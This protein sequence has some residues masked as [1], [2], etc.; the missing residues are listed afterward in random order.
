MSLTKPTLP[1]RALLLIG[2]GVALAHLLLLRELPAALQVQ[3][4][5]P[6]ARALQTRSIAAPPPPV[7]VAPA[8]APP[9]ARPKPPPAPP[10]VQA[11]PTSTTVASV[12][13]P[14][15][16][17]PE[18]AP[19]PEPPASAPEVPVVTPPAPPEPA[20]S[21]PAPPAPPAP[22]AVTQATA[23]AFPA[24]VHLLYELSGESKK[25]RYQARGELQWRQDGQ[26]YDA[27][28]QASMLFFG[29]RTRTSSGQIT[30]SGLAP[31]RF[32]DKWRSEQAAHF[33]QEKHKVTFSANTP[34]VTLQAAAQD[35]LSVILQI[36]GMLAAE[37]ASY[38]A[39]S[40]ITLQTVG[41][42]DADIWAF[43]VETP[44]KIRVPSG[45]LETIKLIRKPRK[46]FDQ[47]VEIWLAP[48]L[49]YLP[50]RLKITNANGDFIDQQ[51]RG[52][53]KP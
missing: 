10:P 22:P 14:D 44:E 50:A 13:T 46:E 25:L 39:G 37:P 5:A 11:P 20:A 49:G 52:V 34:E 8:P 35:Q 45:E 3:G 16:L 27:Q 51:L 15:P 41:P 42:K 24:S 43:T 17:P 53:E 9:I 2:G 40:G 6:T 31:T 32:S 19:L 21:A 48:S 36:A 12:E 30:P 7:A 1:L 33:D 18:P 4:E 23:F 38:P 29:S 28:L 26:H 47:K